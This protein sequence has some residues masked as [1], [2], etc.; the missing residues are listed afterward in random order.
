MSHPVRVRGLKP[1]GVCQDGQHHI[2]APRAGAWVETDGADHE[3][4]RANVAPRAGAWVETMPSIMSNITS[5]S[6]PVRVR[7]LK[8]LLL[9]TC[10]RVPPSHPVRVRGLKLG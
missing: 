3:G 10:L 5:S 2:V 6:H 9:E 7:G 1:D 8:R 4:E